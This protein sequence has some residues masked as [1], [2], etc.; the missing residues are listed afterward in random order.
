MRKAVEG[1]MAQAG[2]GVQLYS[3]LL[4]IRQLMDHRKPEVSFF[5]SHF[6]Q[7]RSIFAFCTYSL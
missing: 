2:L 3:T 5:K 4:T 6:L 1:Q 7:Y